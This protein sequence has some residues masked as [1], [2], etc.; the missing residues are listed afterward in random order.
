MECLY[1][2]SARG[3]RDVVKGAGAYVVVRELHVEVEDERVREWCERVVNVLM[4]DEEGEIP[5]SDKIQEEDEDADDH[6]IVEIF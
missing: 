3:G 1:V 4:V 5:P 2:V 6:T